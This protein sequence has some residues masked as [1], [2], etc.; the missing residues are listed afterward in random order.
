[1]LGGGFLQCFVIR[2]AQDLGYRVVVLDADKNAMGFKLV[3]NGNYEVINI[4][5]EEDCLKYAQ[6]HKVDGVLT[7]AT[8]FSVLTMSR[9]SQEMGLPGINY[10]AAKRIKNK[11]EVRK[12]LFDA[13]ADDT[14]YSFQIDSM[15]Q[16]PEILP[17]VQ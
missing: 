4:V 1:M 10:E 7:A 16:I 3:G 11:A 15:E 14:G 17:Q 13:K 6:K 5:K 8:D 9:I 12:C 2:K